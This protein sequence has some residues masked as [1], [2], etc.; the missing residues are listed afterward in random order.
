MRQHPHQRAGIRQR[1]M[2]TAVIW[3][4]VGEGRE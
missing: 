2:G 1:V 3:Q 4:A